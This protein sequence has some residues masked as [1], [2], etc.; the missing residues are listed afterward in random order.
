LTCVQ[1]SA[2]GQVANYSNHFY[3]YL[4]FSELFENMPLYMGVLGVLAI[5]KTTD[6]CSQCTGI[7][8]QTE[9]TPTQ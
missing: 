6:V 1:Q 8:K 7:L 5:C 4:M 2:R 9:F 3:E